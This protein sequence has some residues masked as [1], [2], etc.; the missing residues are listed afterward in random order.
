VKD[1]WDESDS[2]DDTLTHEQQTDFEK[3]QLLADQAKAMTE[4]FQE[5][6]LSGTSLAEFKLEAKALDGQLVA[7]FMK[8]SGARKDVLKPFL[9]EVGRPG[10]IWYAWQPS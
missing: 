5:C 1:T 7:L 3:L 6:K 4:G 8:L 9:I 2:S 10:L